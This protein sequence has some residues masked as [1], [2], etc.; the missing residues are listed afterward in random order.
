[1]GPDEAATPQ[2]ATAACGV[3]AKRTAQ[4]IFQPPRRS[5]LSI[6]LASASS[7]LYALGSHFSF[8]PIRSAI[9][10]MWQTITEPAPTST[11]VIGVPRLLTQS[12]K[13][14]I[15]SL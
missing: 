5:R 2:A 12:R 9:V 14:P 15:W 4:L 3:A 6:L 7:N 11:P 1:T 13:L 10:P 8:L